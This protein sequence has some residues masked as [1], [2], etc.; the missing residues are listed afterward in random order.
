MKPGSPQTI[1]YAGQRDHVIIVKNA[2]FSLAGEMNV[3]M[4]MAYSA[5]AI[6]VWNAVRF[7]PYCLS[8]RGRT[9]I[10]RHLALAAFTPF[11]GKDSGNRQRSAAM[12]LFEEL[13]SSA[14]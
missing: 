2:L 9:W 13:L 10:S 14:W 1:F 7:K 5:R 11:R 8:F 6:S 3:I 12:T 4:V